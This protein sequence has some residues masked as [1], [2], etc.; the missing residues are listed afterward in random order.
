M[1]ISLNWLSEYLET[2]YSPIELA[3]KL[4]M[5]GIEVE[6]I[7]ETG[8]S[9]PDGV[10][11]AEIIERSPHPD[12]EKL[13]V[14]RV[15]TGDEEVQIVCGAPNCDAGVKAPLATTGT[16]FIDPDSGKKFK[17]K[18]SKLRGVESFGMLCSTQE[19]GLPGDASGIMH[20]PENSEVGCKFSD[21]LD[22]DT[23]YEVE[24]TPNRPDWLSHW[25]VARDLAALTGLQPSFPEINLPSPAGKSENGIISVSDTDLC[26]RYTARII[27]GVKVTES[28]E[29]MQK[30]L[31]NI[32]LR[33]INN[34]VDITNF[35][36]MELG[37]PLHAFDLNML[38]GGK[39]VVRRAENNEKLVTLDGKEQK[40]TPSNL[41][42]C[43]NSKPVAL[44]GVMGGEHSGVTEKSVDILLESAVFNPSNIRATSR[45]L[46]IMSDS[47]FR[48]ER[49]VDWEMCETASDRATAL[50]LELAGGTL[51][52]ELIDIK[53]APPVF[54]DVK[55]RF[56][57]IRKLLGCNITNDEIVAIFAGLKLDVTNISEKECTVTPPSFRLDIYREADLAEEVARI[58]GL[59][60]IT[61]APLRAISGGMIAE[62]AYYKLEEIGN[63]LISFGLNEC[64]NYS[65]I[66]KDRAL[67][68]AKFAESDMKKL[69]NPL[70]LEL[71][72]LRPSLFAQMLETVERNISRQNSDLALF[73]TGRVYCENK[74][75]FP[76]E[77]MEACIALTG[78]KHPE[79]F[80]AEKSEVYD[81]YDL[82]GIIEN[83]FE[84][85][86]MNCEF[87]R[88]PEESK[89]SANFA[90]GTA[91]EIVVNGKTIG[92][93]GQISQKLTK[94]MRITHPLF[95]AVIQLDTLISTPASKIRFKQ[96]PHFPATSRDVAFIADNSL[97]HGKI[98]RTI[99]SAKLPNL[100]TIELFDVFEDEKTIG[101][102]KK[103]MAYS[104][105][106]RHPERTLTDKE[107]NKAHEKL[108][109]K[110]AKDLNIELR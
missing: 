69:K 107:V 6:D 41:V 3:D 24:I 38:D 33:P 92:E 34:I 62:D 83:W 46:K 109:A 53:T 76:E 98:M 37:H 20:L 54:A 11:V 81:F 106:F 28:P 89:V 95:L 57:K 93:I 72:Y 10:I 43:D 68:D 71:A 110:L 35:V 19:L 48:F 99:R 1:K 64:M 30:H 75:L 17:I 29:W 21:T 63:Q 94:G 15:L 12:A 32:G 49:G 103:S 97:E 45:D 108:R 44:A 47:S 70:S 102:G 16:T 86:K 2:P 91:A 8:T 4:T 84:M 58:Y 40:L 61:P 42:I 5:A 36:L 85:R 13:S 66:H 23:V 9:I 77:R 59:N 78:R 7:E 51:E 104:M 87:R 52:T 101:K 96:I 50:I 55:C 100:E 22:S 39:I 65:L 67:V 90:S 79:R 82:K 74:N 18:K 60:K 31:T 80:S 26:P 14:C 105:T 88:I 27:R 73:E 56:E 25:G